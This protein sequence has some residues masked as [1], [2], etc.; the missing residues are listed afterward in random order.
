MRAL[1][2]FLAALPLAAQIIP[3]TGT[4]I[5]SCG[6]RA[7]WVD[8][9]HIIFDSQTTVLSPNAVN[10]QPPSCLYTNGGK[11]DY[12]GTGQWDV[13]E[14]TQAGG[15]WT[16]APTLVNLTSA[17][18][19]ASAVLNADASIGDP[20]T[21]GTHLVATAQTAANVSSATTPGPG[22]GYQIVLANSITSIGNGTSTACTG[23]TGTYGCGVISNLN[24]TGGSSIDAHTF[25]LATATGG[26]TAGTYV[27]WTE[28]NPVTIPA[29]CATYSSSY[30]IPWVEHFALVNWT[31]GTGGIPAI[32]S[33]T[34]WCP[35]TAAFE[36]MLAAH[37]TA[38]SDG[39]CDVYYKASSVVL[40][41]NGTLTMYTQANQIPQFDTY[42]TGA[43]TCENLGLGVHQ[44][45]VEVSGSMSFT[46]TSPP[47]GASVKMI[48]PPASYTA[49]IP[50]TGTNA[51]TNCLS[52]NGNNTC[53]EEFEIS[54]NGQMMY[55]QSNHFIPPATVDDCV[56]QSSPFG[57]CTLHQLTEFSIFNLLDGVS[58]ARMTDQQTRGTAWELAWFPGVS[59]VFPAY[60]GG[61]SH[62]SFNGQWGVADIQSSQHDS[63]AQSQNYSEVIVW[64]T[65]YA[66]NWL[67]GGGE[68]LQNLKTSGRMKW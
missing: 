16:T 57:G 44:D 54:R 33:D 62:S 14:A 49:V 27:Y 51:L 9:T 24:T 31:G 35:Q 38:I 52:P 61:F 2:L 18:H 21:D 60:Y 4:V 58:W 42:T 46:M 40:N 22:T 3:T 34:A 45:G 30:I 43:V 28:R 6:A 19:G 41:P 50:T 36:T 29:A 55:V 32:V 5:S 37:A 63:G 64:Q 53:Y 59:G 26:W 11:P 15:S 56:A 25:T 66:G 17:L 10:V 68:T 48:N 20:D 23:G 67:A 8:S 39:P 13:W 47:L 1:L 65:N 7:S 12:R